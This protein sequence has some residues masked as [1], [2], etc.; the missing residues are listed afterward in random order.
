MRILEAVGREAEPDGTRLAA[1]VGVAT[2]LV[3]VGDVVGDGA[4]RE[5]AVI[6]ETPN[7]AAHLQAIAAPGEVVI[8]DQ[9]R[10]LAGD[11]FVL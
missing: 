7:L 3:V 6:E 2:A 1:R 9:T 10:R 8:A 11:M 5:V 4:A